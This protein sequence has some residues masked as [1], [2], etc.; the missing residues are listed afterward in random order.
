MTNRQMLRLEICKEMMEVIK[1]WGVWLEAVEIT[2][3]MIL[4]NALFKNMQSAF[5]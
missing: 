4:S 2:D 5:R 1:G 3:V